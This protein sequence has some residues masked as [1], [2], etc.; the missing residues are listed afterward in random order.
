MLSL[1]LPGRIFVCKLPTDMRKSF[2]TPVPDQIVSAFFP[3]LTD[4]AGGRA[5]TGRNGTEKAWGRS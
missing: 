5:T 1:A 4:H 3:K 2:D